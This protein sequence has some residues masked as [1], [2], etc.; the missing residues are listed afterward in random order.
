MVA[1]MAYTHLTNM[2]GGNFRLPEIEAV[3]AIEQLKK[4]PRLLKQRI[5]LADYL[6]EHLSKL[7]FLTPPMVREG[8]GHVN[9]LYPIK[10]REENTGLGREK[11]VENIR[12]PWIPLY[13][14]AG[15]YIRPL[16]MEP[17]FAQRDTLKNGYP[18]SM[19]GDEG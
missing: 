9:Y 17:I 4:L 10:Y 18:Y 19:S 8:G 15:G 1:E 6:T 13:R 11:Y 16:Y 14:F 5:A 12:Q 2:L 3:I 7:D